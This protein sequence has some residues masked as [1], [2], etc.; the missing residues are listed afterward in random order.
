MLDDDQ[1]VPY[2]SS[3]ECWRELGESRNQ[4]PEQGRHVSVSTQATVADVV[5]AAAAAAIAVE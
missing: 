1:P 5:A 2:R 4:Q 3:D